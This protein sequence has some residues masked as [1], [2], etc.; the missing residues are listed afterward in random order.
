MNR[1]FITLGITVLGATLSMTCHADRMVVLKG[2]AVLL[3]ADDFLS[4]FPDSPNPALSCSFNTATGTFIPGAS[5]A[6]QIPIP[7]ATD[8]KVVG[9]HAYVATSNFENSA[10]VTG[11]VKYDISACMPTGPFTPFRAH[12]NLGS[13]ELVIP[14]VEVDGNEYNVIMNQRGNSMNW[15][16]QFV[17]TGCY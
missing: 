4:V 6:I 7:G 17:N 11:Y 15:E 9:S 10:A 16:V 8:V 12:A 2:N 14:C 1:L 13:G 3:A 5:A